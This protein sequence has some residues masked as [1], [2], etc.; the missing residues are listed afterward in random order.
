FVSIGKYAAF[1]EIQSP[2][3]AVYSNRFTLLTPQVNGG[4]YYFDDNHDGVTDY[5]ISNPDFNY[6]QFRSNLVIRWEFKVGSALYLVWSQDRTAIQ[7]PGLFDFSNGFN[8][9]FDLYPRNIV[10]IKFNYLFKN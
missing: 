7:Q 5:N 1:K 2:H 10:M 9:L 3:D 6:Q 4:R 8:H